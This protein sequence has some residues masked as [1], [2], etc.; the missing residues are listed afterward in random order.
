MAKYGASIFGGPGDPGT[1]STGYRGDNLNKKWRSFAELSNDPQ[2]GTGAD[3]AAMG[4]LKYGTKVKVT[5]PKTGK[6]LVLKKRDV[7]AGG[8]AVGGK[9]RGIDLWYKAGQYLGING[10]GV[11][12]VEVLTGKEK[13]KKIRQGVGGGEQAPQAASGASEPLSALLRESIANPSADTALTGTN[14]A[15]ALLS[16]GQNTPTSKVA[17]TKE[18]SDKARKTNTNLKGTALFEGH[19]VAAWIKP[20]LTYARRHGWKGQINSGYRSF[21]DQTRIYNSG[22][23]PA[24]KPGTS[25]HEGAD[26]PRGAI[27]VSDAQQL[28]AILRKKGGRLK[29]AGAKDP[30]HFSHPHG[31]S[32]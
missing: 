9:K 29:Y 15:K 3:F 6:S 17:A 22:V 16:R 20:E 1:G 8:G 26:Y 32:Y 19:R 10:T 4:G 12:D 27:D 21:A 7:G 14:I 28:A 2:N 31:G 5:N 23:R 13:G 24:A 30:V 18:V 11:V 25:N